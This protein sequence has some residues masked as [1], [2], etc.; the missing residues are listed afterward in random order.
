MDIENLI[1]FTNDGTKYL[2]TTLTAP[3]GTIIPARLTMATGEIK[4][5]QYDK[6]APQRKPTGVMDDSVLPAWMNRIYADPAAC[7]G[8]PIKKTRKT[9]VVVNPYYGKLDN[10]LAYHCEDVSLATILHD[11][12][13]MDNYFTCVANLGD[14]NPI[15]LNVLLRMLRELPE[16]DSKAVA[17]LTGFSERHCR[18][19][20]AAL[21]LLIQ[22]KPTCNRFNLEE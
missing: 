6:E 5:Y 9:N 13:E 2:R 14:N 22:L 19:I 8:I 16:I 15:G 21:H 4:P 10:F 3:N 18:R 17:R 12:P 7:D 1:A 20:T 11:L